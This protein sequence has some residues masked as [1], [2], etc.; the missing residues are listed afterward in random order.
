[1]EKALKNHLVILQL[2]LEW[3]AHWIEFLHFF[4][5]THAIQ[6]Q[7]TPPAPGL[8]AGIGFLMDSGDSLLALRRSLAFFHHSTPRL[9]DFLD[10]FTL[11]G[12]ARWK[13]QYLA[14]P[15]E[16][17]PPTMLEILIWL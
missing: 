6:E 4:T 13:C 5:S 16:R 12:E 7:A 9:M 1:M 17:E 11:A 8:L 15:P 14:T 3:R 10:S 2:S